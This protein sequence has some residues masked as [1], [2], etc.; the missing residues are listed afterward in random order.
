MLVDSMTRLSEYRDTT[1]RHLVD[2][3]THQL[4]VFNCLSCDDLRKL[5]DNLNH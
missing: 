3:P 2:N 5:T 4:N 1:C